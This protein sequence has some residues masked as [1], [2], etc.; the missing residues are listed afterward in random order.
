[1]NRKDQRRRP[2]A[3][4]A[5]SSRPAGGLTLP[6]FSC[7]YFLAKFESG[8]YL[9]AVIYSGYMCLHSPDKTA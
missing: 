1:M 9:R 3:A 8:R 7:N 5:F 2:A 6:L 4:A